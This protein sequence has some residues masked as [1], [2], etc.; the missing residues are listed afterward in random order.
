MVNRVGTYRWGYDV[1]YP[2]PTL[3]FDLQT[4][5]LVNYK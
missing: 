2:A 1:D 3:F 5:F 4:Q